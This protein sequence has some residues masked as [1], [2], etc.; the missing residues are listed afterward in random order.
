MF[1][2]LICASGHF[3]F[4]LEEQTFDSPEM[5]FATRRAFFCFVLICLIPS[6]SRA[7]KAG[8]DM[9]KAAEKFL[10]S[11]DPVQQAK[12][13]FALNSDER[14][15]WHFVPKARLG[16]PLK[17]M[18]ESQRELA[19]GLLRSGL[20]QRGYAEAT[21]IMS[22]ELVLFDMEKKNPKRDPELYYFSV[23]EKPGRTNN[24]GWRVE[25]HH[26]SI[27]FTIANGEEISTTPFF[28]GSNPGEVKEGARKGV[29][30]LGNE[31]DLG[32]RLVQSLT[33]EQ[34]KIAIIA[35][36]APKEIFTSNARQVKP[37]E[38]VGLAQA[39]MSKNQ[40]EL[41]IQLIKEYLF[42]TRPEIAQADMAEIERAGV[43]AI[44]F[45]WA[46]GLERGEPHY[47]RVQG[48]TFLLEYDNTQNNANHVHTVWRDFRND[49]GEDL[50]RQHYEQS[51]HR[52]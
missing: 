23:F 32:R 45:A 44:T 7:E 15:N 37:L 29:R 16:L 26:V 5:K 12:A 27:N 42:R 13:S 19:R 41:L 24:W 51:P 28:L 43:G 38:P 40:R 8:A 4:A 2:E 25:G 31:E 14:R 35:T 18:T 11:L 46:G 17:E 52:N 49:F 21:T 6:S 10:A 20:S 30:V 48:S 36:N 33:P 50:L 3:P 39:Q 47:Y 1:R 22:L 34:K 9:A